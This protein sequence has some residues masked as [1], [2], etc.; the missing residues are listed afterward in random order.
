MRSYSYIA[1]T[2][3][4]FGR[5]KHIL[6]RIRYEL[7]ERMNFHFFLLSR[8]YSVHGWL[9]ANI[10][11][12]APNNTVHV[13]SVGAW[14]ELRMSEMAHN[15]FDI[16]HNSCFQ[17]YLNRFPRWEKLPPIWNKR[18]C[19]EHEM[20]RSLQNR[21]IPMERRTN[22]LFLL[23][24][25]QFFVLLHESNNHVLRSPNRIGWN[26]KKEEKKNK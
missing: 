5:M 13:G 3:E 8:K 11:Q 23:R 9:V 19:L 16:Q 2:V 17:F 7:Q 24:C 22:L 4:Y 15:K 25:N 1:Y 21:Q 6:N 18:P 26:E 10:G 14:V 12:C 20:Y